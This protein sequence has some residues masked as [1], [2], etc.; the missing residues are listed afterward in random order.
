MVPTSTTHPPPRRRFARDRHVSARP[1]S[2]SVL[3][4]SP[5]SKKS[6]GSSL[7]TRRTRYVLD[8]GCAAETH[9]FSQCP[10]PLPSLR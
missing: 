5:A 3:A 7:G 10:A 4:S 2:A 6:P 1:S 9:T 8:A